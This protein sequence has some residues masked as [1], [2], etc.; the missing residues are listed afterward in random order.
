MGLI[1]LA[2]TVVRTFYAG[3]DFVAVLCVALALFSAKSARSAWLSR[4]REQ[5]VEVS[6]EGVRWRDNDQ[7][8][9]VRFEDVEKVVAHTWDAWFVEFVLKNGERIHPRF[10]DYHGLLNAVRRRYRGPI[11]VE[12][13]EVGP[14][15]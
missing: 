5:V 7:E 13:K 15:P 4:T 6:Y 10:P 12:S 1:A 3:F 14:L 11:W 8:L 9:S 2:S